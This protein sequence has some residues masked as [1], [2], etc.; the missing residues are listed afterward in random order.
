MSTSPSFQ[1]QTES[2]RRLH[3]QLVNVLGPG[4]AALYYD[5]VR[6]LAEASPYIS[7]THLV[8]HLLREIESSLRRV[9]LPY[10]YPRPAE[11]PCCHHKPEVEGHKKQ[12][13]A[14]AGIYL[15]DKTTSELW[16]ALATGSKEHDHGF[17]AFAHRDALTIPRPLDDACKQM[18]T[19]FEQVLFT[20][21]DAFERQ[22]LHIYMFL[23]ELLAKAQPGKDDV[24]KL[25]NK[26][27]ANWATYSYF[28]SRLDDPIWLRPLSQ[29]N[30]FA[31]PSEDVVEGY[32]RYSPWPQ[33]MYLKKMA[34]RDQ[35]VQEQVL[36]ILVTVAKTNNPL[37]QRAILEIAQLLPAHLSARLT[38]FV[39]TWIAE[40]GWLSYVSAELQQFIAHLV[41]GGHTPSAIALLNALLLAM[42][43]ND[44]YIE[45]WDYKHLL[46]D[47]LPAFVMN[48]PREL[49]DL[50]CTLLD[51]D[52]YQHYIRFRR[53][54]AEDAAV[55]DRA[56]EAST[57]TW[58]PT[59]EATEHVHVR[60]AQSLVLFAL[61]LRKAAEQAINDRYLSLS[62][63]LSLLEI[64]T[65]RIFKRL[66]LYLLS[67][68]ASDDL[69]LARSWLM[70]R[71][72]FNDADLRHEYS[73]LAQVTLPHL[74]KEEQAT[75]LQWIEEG[76]DLEAYK[77]WYQKTYQAL[78]EAH[79]IQQFKAVWQR[80][81]LGRI[82]KVLP[83]E[84]RA[85][86]DE[87]V[88]QYG[89]YEP[90]FRLTSWPAATRISSNDTHRHMTVE[91][92]LQKLGASQNGQDDLQVE[93]SLSH[94]TTLI[95][96]APERFANQVHLF[97]EQPPEVIKAVIRGLVQAAQ[98]EHPFDWYQ[99]LHLCL[100]II[101]QR[102]PSRGEEKDERFYDPDW[103]SVS[104]E[105]ALLCL[106]TFE[107][108]PSQLPYSSRGTIWQLLMALT[109]DPYYL[110]IAKKETTPQHY[111]S[112]AIN[113]TEGIAFQ[114]VI[115]YAWWVMTNWKEEQIPQEAAA[116]DLRAVCQLLCK[117][118]E[119]GCSC[120]VAGIFSFT[121]RKLRTTA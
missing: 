74:T 9:L 20:V 77:Q 49:L 27:P 112:D 99:V 46:F 64:H 69:T 87:L 18:M 21:L 48:A 68:F 51:R 88:A 53:L 44:A 102:M 43:T 3:Q 105:V 115:S 97:E 82:E 103:A 73:Q 47:Q 79:D 75:W 60:G 83:D 22:S 118:V 19:T 17:A 106:T 72:L 104:F 86:Y 110:S 91:Q 29:K 31:I 61:A 1:L 35:K 52:I 81:W 11:C 92:W 66:I 40:P 80:D 84:W 117:I 101:E 70:T 24:S 107:K 55:Y 28:F 39:N 54:E 67:Q 32:L 38:P 14:I 63:T 50:L 95:A 90:E 113:S 36:S 13:E 100:W 119:A 114:A 4:P 78:P 34:T 6:M 12:I 5:A 30:A 15:L 108:L 33:A 96:E 85:R 89:A 16:I 109:G 57:I 10:D 120:E 116:W 56:R 121:N 45:R 65:G 37:A 94:L 62:E 41:E 7:T 25:K 58:L 98:A 23:D 111:Y 93:V 59:F 71:T 26:V 42:S 76:P 8:A 2:Q